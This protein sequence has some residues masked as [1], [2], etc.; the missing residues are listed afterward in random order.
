MSSTGAHVATV[1]TPAGFATVICQVYYWLTFTYKKR[2]FY[3]QKLPA[4][5]ILI[6]WTWVELFEM[7][8]KIERGLNFVLDNESRFFF[9]ALEA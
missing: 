4:T 9:D 6:K 8:V 1:C 7:N 2:R 5:G 3:R